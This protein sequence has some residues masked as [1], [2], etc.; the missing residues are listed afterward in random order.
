MDDPFHA[1]R[2]R[3]RQLTPPSRDSVR[4]FA[5]ESLATNG[6]SGYAGRRATPVVVAGT[7]SM[8]VPANRSPTSVVGP[9]GRIRSCLAPAAGHAL[10]AGGHVT[11]AGAVSTGGYTQFSSLVMSVGHGLWPPTA[12]RPSRVREAR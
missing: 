5:E 10:A 7:A 1:M 2:D 3:A 11:E 9:R 6:A 12:P 4:P 8:T